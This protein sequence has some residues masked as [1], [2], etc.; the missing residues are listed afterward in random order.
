MVLELTARKVSLKKM[1]ELPVTVI[2]FLV[3]ESGFW[4]SDFKFCFSYF[5]FQFTIHQ[6]SE[7]A[8]HAAVTSFV[9]VNV[10]GSK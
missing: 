2:D 4:F 6:T 5:W 7:L 3:A 1:T 10:E 9:S 8:L